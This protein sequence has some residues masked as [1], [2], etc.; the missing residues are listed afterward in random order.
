MVLKSLYTAPCGQKTRQ[1]TFNAYVTIIGL[2]LKCEAF[3]FD[4]YEIV[5][6]ALNDICK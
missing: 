6:P 5:E 1:C 2:K 4:E 3:P